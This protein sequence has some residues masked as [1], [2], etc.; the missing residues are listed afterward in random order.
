MC[1]HRAFTSIQR[2][3]IAYIYSLHL[4]FASV[5]LYFWNYKILYTSCAKLQYVV[6]GQLLIRNIFGW[7]SK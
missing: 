5:Q 2:A 6:L 1:V 3:S 4:L 7:H